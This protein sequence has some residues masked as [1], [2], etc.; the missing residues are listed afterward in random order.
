MFDVYPTD[1]DIVARITFDNDFVKSTSDTVIV[2]P[3]AWKSIDQAVCAANIVGDFVRFDGK[4]RIQWNVKLKVHTFT[5]LFL[6]SERIAESW[7]RR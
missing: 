1:A 7:S 6:I 2:L 3:I 5:R 4:I